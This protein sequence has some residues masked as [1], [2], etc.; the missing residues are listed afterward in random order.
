MDERDQGYDAN[1]NDTN[2]LKNAQ[3]AGLG[4]WRAPCRG[5]K[6]VAAVA[7]TNKQ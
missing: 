7:A 5:Q 3:R 1:G 2:S 6:E 4:P